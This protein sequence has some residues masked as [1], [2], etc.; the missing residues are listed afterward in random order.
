MNSDS[1]VFVAGHRGLVGSALVRRL[2]QEGCSQLVLRSSGELDLRR[3][4][5]VE[6]FFEEQRPEYV[7]LAAAKVGGI[8]ANDTYPAEFIADNLQIQSNVIDAAYR[9]GVRKLLFLGSSCVYPKHAPQPMPESCLLTGA[10]EPTNESYAVAKIAGIKMCE[11]YRRQYGFDAICA[12]PTNLYGPGDN[13]DLERSHVLPALLRKLHEAKLRGASRVTVWG[14]GAPRREFMHVDDLADACVFLMRHYQG[15]D[16]VNIGWGEDL[17]I[18]ELAELLREVVGF[19]GALEFDPSRP[20]GTPRKLLDVAR[21]RALG[22]APRV[23]LPQG[24]AATYEWFAAHY[25]PG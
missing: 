11:A 14:T 23:A 8:H 22:W 18:R 4:H 15:A 7:F 12:M 10:L 5:A 21:L 24:T 19:K 6:R 2:R 13:F 3:Q 17:S 20:D 9:H 25:R 1:R 16:L